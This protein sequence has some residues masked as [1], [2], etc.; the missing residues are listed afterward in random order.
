MHCKACGKK[1]EIYEIQAK[2]KCEC[3][4]NEATTK[5][6]KITNSIL[7]GTKTLIEQVNKVKKW[8]S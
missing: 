5:D 7:V 2:N 4:S 6:Q 3:G 8:H 1:R